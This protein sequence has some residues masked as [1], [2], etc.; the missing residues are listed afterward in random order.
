MIA[1]ID[2]GA[3]N[4]K[5]IKNMLSQLNLQSVITNDI[6]TIYSSE[7][8]ILP[9]VGSYDF[10]IKS[11][12]ALGLEELLNEIVIIKKKPI[13]GICLGAQLLGLSS[14]EGI[15]KGLG[16]LDF[17]CK[18]FNFSDLTVPCMGWNSVDLTESE[19]NNKLFKNLKDLNEFYFAHSYYIPFDPRY[20]LG[21]SKYRIQYASVV[22]VGNVFGVQFHPEKSHRFGMSLLQNF[23]SI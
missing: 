9:G 4:L 3:G 1:I 13:L 16:W 2:Y 18:K 22:S 7:R 12:R 21:I 11:I 10:G 17:D 23:S 20:G 14:E 5:S 19:I 6:D 8:I 15:E